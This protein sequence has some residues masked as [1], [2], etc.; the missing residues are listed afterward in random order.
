[1]KPQ[2]HCKFHVGI[3]A[4][5]RLSAT[6]TLACLP[7]ATLAAGWSGYVAATSDNVYRGLTQSAGDPSLSA[8]LHWR[9]DSGWFAGLGLATVNRNPGPGAPLEI[10]TYLG[11]S[12]A[13]SASVN[14]RLSVVHYEYPHERNALPYGYDELLGALSWRDRAALNFSYSANT[15]RFTFGAI[16]VHR[17]AWSLEGVWRQPLSLRWSIAT[18]LGRYAMSTPIGD[19]YWYWNVSLVGRRDP[20]RLELS[21]IGTD[22]RA[23]QL[24]GDPIAGQRWVI[25][26]IKR[27]PGSP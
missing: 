5:A 9:G 1:M 10:A 3:A 22:S 21:A 24:F 27:I 16:A 17:P 6:A 26:L 7:G 8:D 4:L 13:L 25:S 19:A 14:A 2:A 12:A 11:R 20:W 23:R 15:S 18:G